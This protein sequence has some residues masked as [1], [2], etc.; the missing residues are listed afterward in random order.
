MAII[1]WYK[2]YTE[3]L[4][5]TLVRFRIVYP[6]FV[7]EKITYAGR[8]DPLAHGLM[9][10]LTGADVHRKEAFLGYDKVYEVSYIIGMQT[11]TYDILGIPVYVS[12]TLPEQDAMISAIHQLS[13][14]KQ[15]T[16]PAYSSKTVGGKPLF[17]WAREGLLD[18]LLI[19]SRDI[20]ISH[21][22][23][24]GSIPVS[25]GDMHIRIIDSINNVQGDFRQGDSISAW[26]DYFQFSR[27]TTYDLYTISVACSSG[28]YM[29]T[30][31]DTLGRTLG[32]GA[33][34]VVIQRT[35]LGPY[36]LADCGRIIEY[37]RT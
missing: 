25:A 19:P 1:C 27:K 23:Y 17:A 8:L 24:R 6:D 26:N 10:L 32:V 31:I 35:H 9:L 12:D 3:T 5:E 13:T 14:T 15:Q 16:Y 7:H 18:T 37:P 4:A 36:T 21:I 30:L 28:T 34:S 2:N 20:H 33:C 11:D 29:R 22:G